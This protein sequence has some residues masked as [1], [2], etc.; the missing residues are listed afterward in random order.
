M[1]DTLRVATWHVD[2]SRRGPGLL[3]RDIAAGDDPGVTAVVRG[4]AHAAPDILLLTGIDWDH[5]G[6]TLAALA[7]RLAEAGA[8]YP[9]RLSL[10]PNS[11]LMSRLDLDGDGRHGGPGDRQGFGRYTGHGGMALLSRYPFAAAQGRDFSALL[12]ADLPGALLPEAGGA[13]FP[14]AEAVAAQRLSSAGHR[15]VPVILGPD[16]QLHLLVFAAG[17]PVFDGPEDRNG[18]RNH[19]EIALWLRYLDGALADPPPEAPVIVLGNANLDPA[20]GEGWRDAIRALLAHGRLSD[21][22]P[23]SAGGAMAAAE[24]GGAN[25]RHRGDPAPDTADWRDEDGP[26]NL[27]VSYVLPDRRLGVTGAGVLWPVP[28]GPLDDD[29]SAEGAPRHRLVWVDVAL[30]R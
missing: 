21:P 3:L 23:T 25:A 18:R 5:D 8:V 14:S 13:P 28:G 20:D 15:D 2:L 26:G 4:V 9:N 27:R 12:W 6:H 30:E 10:R 11:T 17:P 1:A 19:D 7:A 22:A 16:R 24:Q 29:L